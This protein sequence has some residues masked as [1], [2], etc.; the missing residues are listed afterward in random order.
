MWVGSF[1]IAAF[2][3]LDMLSPRNLRSMVAGIADSIRV[4][5]L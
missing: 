4:A 2:R 3:F 5:V 1:Q